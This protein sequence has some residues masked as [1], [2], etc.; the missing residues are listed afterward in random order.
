MKKYSLALLFLMAVLML[1]YGWWKFKKTDS[2]EINLQ[3]SLKVAAIS[4]LDVGEEKVKMTSKII[5][6]NPLPIHIKTDRLDYSVFIDSIKIVESSYNKPIRIYSLKDTTIEIPIDILKEPLARLLKYLEK[7]NKETAEY[8]VKA[9]IKVDIPVIGE[10]KFFMEFSKRLPAFRP[11]KLEIED[12]DVDS[13]GFDESKIDLV[14]Q[15]ANPNIFALKLKDGKYGFTVDNDIV[16]EGS[17]EKIIDIPAKSSSPVSIH[18]DLKTVKMGKFLWK[19][20]FDKTGTPFNLKFRCKLLTD[21]DVLTN[22][23]ITFNIRGTLD[24][25]KKS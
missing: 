9:D 6:S 18:L 24:K 1:G 13:L 16:M 8:T 14:A 19:M 21:K 3:P 7:N 2:G 25:L 5:L 20:L 10:K 22:S 23:H 17:L 11:P 12:V 4:N 15:V